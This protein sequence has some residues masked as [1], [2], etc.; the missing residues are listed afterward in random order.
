MRVQT[1]KPEW[2]TT[3]F[4][5]LLVGSFVVA[6]GMSLVSLFFGQ[7]PLPNRALSFAAFWARYI[8]GALV[9]FLAFGA[10]G[11]LIGWW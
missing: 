2:P 10:I 9:F 1:A 11:R 6:C 3:I 8:A 5:A 4:V 7:G